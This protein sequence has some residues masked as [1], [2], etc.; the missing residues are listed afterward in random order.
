MIDMTYPVALIRSMTSRIFRRFALCM[1]SD[2]PTPRGSGEVGSPFIDDTS[3]V[4][5]REAID[6]IEDLLLLGGLG[7][8]GP[9][10]FQPGSLYRYADKERARNGSMRV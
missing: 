3:G 6:E 10:G 4:V 8:I 7:G 1:G 2:R 5:A 9:L